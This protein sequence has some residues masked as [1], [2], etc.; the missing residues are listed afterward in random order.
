MQGW[1]IRRSAAGKIAL[2]QDGDGHDVK[3]ALAGV[4]SSMAALFYCYLVR[5]I[6]YVRDL[7]CNCY[8]RL[9]RLGRYRYFRSSIQ[10]WFQSL[11]RSEH[12]RSRTLLHAGEAPASE[13][14]GVPGRD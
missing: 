14:R 5:P 10:F 7:A 8:C 3:S 9:D 6:L 13:L 1:D 12:E 11:V 4:I 2:G